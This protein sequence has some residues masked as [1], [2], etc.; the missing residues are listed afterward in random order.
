MSDGLEFVWDWRLLVGSLL[1]FLGGALC[2]G[3]GIGG[4]AF[5]LSAFMLV[6]GFDAHYAVPLP[7]IV[8][9]DS[10]TA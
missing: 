5:Y 6:C 4:G 9:F 7:K 2:A 3:G 10:G 1:C 8:I